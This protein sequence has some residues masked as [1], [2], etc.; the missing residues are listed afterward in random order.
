[1]KTE[2][3]SWRVSSE[4]KSDLQRAARHRRVSLASVL[5]EAAR[6]WLKESAARV[7]DDEGQRK[8]HATAEHFIGALSG[9]GPADARSMRKVVRRRL[10]R[11]YGH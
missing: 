11:R 2:V 9:L 3:Y 1:M 6:K 7:S 10:A 4:L 8:L 5:E